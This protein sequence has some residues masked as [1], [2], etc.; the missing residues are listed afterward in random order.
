MC[1]IWLTIWCAL[2][3]L[4]RIDPLQQRQTASKPTLHRTVRVGMQQ[5]LRPNPRIQWKPGVN[6]YIP[7][8]ARVAKQRGMPDFDRWYN[9]FFLG[10]CFFGKFFSVAENGDA[11]PC[12]YNDA[13]RLG[14]VK[15]KPLAD[16]G[17]HAKQRV[18]HQSQ[19]QKQH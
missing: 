12:S 15:D 9:G 11:I 17:G 19:R 6:V 1:W 7:F 5:T 13:Y 8:Y 2:G 10:R 3:G 14:N 4:P 16:L 18:L